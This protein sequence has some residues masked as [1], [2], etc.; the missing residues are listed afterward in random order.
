[1]F[2]GTVPRTN[3]PFSFFQDRFRL[4]GDYRG[5]GSQK[6]SAG[7]EFDSRERSLQEV[8]TTR[9]TTLWGRMEG[10]ATER[11]LL[12]GKLAH[13][14]RNSSTYGVAAWIDPPQNPLMRK[15]YLA[16]RR[17][18][19]AG[20]RADATLQEGFNVGLGVDYA[21]DK[22]TESTIGL[23]DARSVAFGLDFS[24]AIT[25]ETELYGFAQTERITSNQAGSQVFALPDWTGRSEDRIDTVGLGLKHLALD[26]K[27]ELSADAVLTRMRNDVGVDAGVASPPFPAIETSVERLRVRAVYRLRENLSLVGSWWYEHYDSEDWHLD[28]V[29]PATI[30]NLLAFGEQAPRYN[31]HVLQVAVRYRF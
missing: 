22:Y 8:V 3:Q 2:L 1:M 15:F 13:G 12:Q 29:L 6:T 31:V 5:P 11:L 7:I 9:E 25:E 19:S 26:G 10:R 20:A 30:T 28:G 4:G 24:A 27:L 23:T 17:R 14:Q 18:D 16:E 21:K